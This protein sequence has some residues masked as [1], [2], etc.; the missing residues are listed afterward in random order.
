[1]ENVRIRQEVREKTNPDLKKEKGETEKDQPSAKEVV[2]HPVIFQMVNVRTH[3]E[4][5][6]KTN[7]DLKKEKEVT[8]RH[9][10]PEAARPIRLSI[11]NPDWVSKHPARQNDSVARKMPLRE[12]RHPITTRNALPVL[13]IGNHSANA[14]KKQKRAKKA[15]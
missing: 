1:M 9:S 15:A 13:P 3:Q 2:D 14:E 5:Q 12:D 10:V 7:P 4:V 8:D 11:R 6:E